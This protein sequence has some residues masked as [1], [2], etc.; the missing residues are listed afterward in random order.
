MKIKWHLTY[1]CML[2][3][4][5]RSGNAGQKAPSLSA[6]ETVQRQISLIKSYE[7]IAQIKSGSG[8]VHIGTDWWF[9]QVPLCQGGC[10]T[11]TRHQKTGWD[12]MLARCAVTMG[13]CLGT[14]NLFVRSFSCG[15]TLR[16]PVPDRPS[17]MV[18]AVSGRGVSIASLRLHCLGKG[19]SAPLFLHHSKFLP[20]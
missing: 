10:E 11:A 8:T 14:S 9:L 3:R 1:F 6:Y 13:G 16:L 4:H 20:G 5:I 12:V 19:C 2:Y 15:N 7:L 17:L 18:T